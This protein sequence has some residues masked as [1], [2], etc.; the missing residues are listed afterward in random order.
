MNILTE[1]NEV[2]SEWT[3]WEVN[4]KLCAWGLTEEDA[5]QDLQLKLVEE[6]IKDE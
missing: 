4:T 1:Y 5:I 6:G 2:D 3:A